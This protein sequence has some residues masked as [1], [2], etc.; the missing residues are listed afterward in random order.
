MFENAI[1][2]CSDLAQHIATH[3]FDYHGEASKG[4]IQVLGREGE[5]DDETATTFVSAV[6]FRNV[7]AHEYGQVDYARCTKRSRPGWLSTTRS[8]GRSHSGPA[9]ETNASS[10]DGFADE[11]PTERQTY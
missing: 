2:A 10:G 1:Q 5:I 4:A 9:T 6:G 11:P 8:A 7:L 3:D